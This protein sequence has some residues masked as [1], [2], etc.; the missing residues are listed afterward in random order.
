MSD[1]PGEELNDR[2]SDAMIETWR[3][4]EDLGLSRLEVGH[5]LVLGAFDLLRNLDCSNCREELAGVLED[6]GAE[7]ERLK[8]GA[9][10]WN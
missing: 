6:I 7:L 9:G 8:A 3:R 2:I 10:D 1:E 4:F 5:A